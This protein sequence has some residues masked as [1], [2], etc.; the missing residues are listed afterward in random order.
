M[1][2]ASAMAARLDVFPPVQSALMVSGSP[3][4]PFSITKPVLKVGGILYD[5]AACRSHR[6]GLGLL[7]RGIAGAHRGRRDL[8][9]Q[10]STLLTSSGLGSKWVSS[11]AWPGRL[12]AAH[13]GRPSRQTRPRGRIRLCRRGQVRM[14]S[15]V[16][17]WWKC[18]RER[19][20]RKSI[21]RFVVRFVFRRSRV[22]VSP[23]AHAALQPPADTDTRR[24][25]GSTH[26]ERE[27]VTTSPTAGCAGARR[28]EAAGRA[29]SRTA[30]ARPS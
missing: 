25:R 28:P 18:E 6:S 20:P 22:R 27:R 26:P 8:Q 16:S 29:R 9:A 5:A 2:P 1:A 24:L 13:E 12:G 14:A 7:V 15:Y 11:R 4:R 23:V 19:R 17:R 10:C 3:R 21:L 30:A